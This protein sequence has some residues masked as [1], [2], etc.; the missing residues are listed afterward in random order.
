MMQLASVGGQITRQRQGGALSQAEGSQI[1]AEK[2]AEAQEKC[3]RGRNGGG[4]N[5]GP[6]TARKCGN[7]RKTG[8]NARPCQV[9]EEMSNIVLISF[10]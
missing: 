5:G 4:K 10:N 3:D 1:L 6:A 8:H 7:C 9:D 2:D